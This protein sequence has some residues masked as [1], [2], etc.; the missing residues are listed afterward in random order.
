[1][2]IVGSDKAPA[3]V[4]PYSQ[5][6]EVNGLLF[7]SGMLPIN[8]DNGEIEVTDVKNQ[9]KQ[10]LDNIV[11]LL[12]SQGLSL[13]DVVKATIFLQSM[14]DFTDVNNVYATYF[15]EHKPARS[16]VAVKEIPKKA[17]VEIEV[18]AR[19]VGGA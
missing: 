15:N 1:M 3:A 14:D 4:G 11:A 17:L 12:G 8:P 13:N 9:T 18:I 6:I 5:G 16:C 10:V 2:K 7:L 19:T